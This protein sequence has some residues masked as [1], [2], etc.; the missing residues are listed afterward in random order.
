MS[1]MEDRKVEAATSIV[2]RDR[3]F[4]RGK[5]QARWWLHNDPYATAIFNALSVSFPKGEAFFVDSVRQLRD[6]V[7]PEH[8]ADV[9]A[10]IQQEVMHSR[11]HVA[12]NRRVTDHGYDV[13]S[14]DQ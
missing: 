5:V 8:A 10:F 12:F 4:G 14:L 1:G 9:A 3:R 7:R 11:E 13:R 2:P 6:L